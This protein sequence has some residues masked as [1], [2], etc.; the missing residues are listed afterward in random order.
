MFVSRKSIGALLFGAF[1]AMSLIVAVQ[2][3]YGFGALRALGDLGIA[4]QRADLAAAI[5][6]FRFAM[7]A[8]LAAAILFVLL[9]AALAILRVARPWSEAAVVTDRIAEIRLTDALETSD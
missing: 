9:V 1:F 7:I 6:Q 3:I 2:G 8:G 4:A 5:S